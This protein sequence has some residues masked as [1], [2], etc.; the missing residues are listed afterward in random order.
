ML[1]WPIRE[2]RIVAA[3]LL[4]AICDI[5]ARIAQQRIMKAFLETGAKRRRV[6]GQCPCQGFGDSVP[7]KEDYVSA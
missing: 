6:Q 7:K 5:A 4:L 1:G 3:K 2:T